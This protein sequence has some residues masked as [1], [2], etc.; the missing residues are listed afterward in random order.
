MDYQID[1]DIPLPTYAAKGQWEEYLSS[2]LPGHSIPFEDEF[3]EPL[4]KRANSFATAMRTKF[5]KG[6]VTTQKRTEN[7]RKVTRVWRRK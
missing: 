4:N 6:S 7:G 2:M 3:G 5:G 1:Q